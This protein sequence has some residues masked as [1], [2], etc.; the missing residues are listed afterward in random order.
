MKIIDLVNLL[1]KF[2]FVDKDRISCLINK[3]VLDFKILIWEY[4]NVKQINR[5]VL[6][7]K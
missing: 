5:G 4:R 2:K 1:I 3:L 6:Q 7:R